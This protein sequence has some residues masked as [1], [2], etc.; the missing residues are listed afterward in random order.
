M[1][2]EHPS[3]EDKGSAWIRDDG[4]AKRIWI[5]RFRQ[6]RA[7]LFLFGRRWAAVTV[8]LTDEDIDR[9]QSGRLLACDVEDEYI[10]ILRYQPST[11]RSEAHH[12]G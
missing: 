3:E 8:T 7:G 9:L 4:E 11:E 6:D 10:A 12:V 5:K 2:R 1:G